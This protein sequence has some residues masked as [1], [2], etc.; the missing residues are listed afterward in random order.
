MTVYITKE[1]NFTKVRI[2]NNSGTIEYLI[3]K[4]VNLISKNNVLT[5][6]F[7][8]KESNEGPDTI[9]IDYSSIS[10][11]LGSANLTEYLSEALSLNYFTT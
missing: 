10:D 5:I 2:V 9:I 8:E 6:L 3:S 1:T 11:K 7:N 4:P